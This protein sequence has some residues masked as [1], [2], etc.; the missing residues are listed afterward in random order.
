MEYSDAENNE[1]QQD[2]TSETIGT[3]TPSH[4]IVRPLAMAMMDAGCYH[5]S[6]QAI[7]CHGGES[8]SSM[9]EPI[10]YM[11]AS[12]MTSTDQDYSEEEV[13]NDDDAADDDDDDD[14]GHSS[15]LSNSALHRRSRA[16]VGATASSSTTRASS[17]SSS[18][19][20]STGGSS[21]YLQGQ[22]TLKHRKAWSM[23]SPNPLQRWWNL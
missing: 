14:D 21:T 5:V 8:A 10:V 22:V 18:Q 1:Y 4:E 6:A 16:L 11:D 13:E 19:G 9:M 23:V 17:Y 2:E 15:M 20:S 3:E 7:M 12:V